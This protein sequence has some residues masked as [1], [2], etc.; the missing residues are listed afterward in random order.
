MLANTWARVLVN[1]SV[2]G[3]VIGI[4]VNVLAGVLDIVFTDTVIGVG[5][6]MFTGVAV[7]ASGVIV[8]AAEL[9]LP[10]SYAPTDVLTNVWAESVVNID[11]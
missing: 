10:L 11:V 6:G 5:N 3:W 7:N 1:T 9:A 8:I 4:L 2:E